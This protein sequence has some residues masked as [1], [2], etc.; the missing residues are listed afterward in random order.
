MRE[1]RHERE[2][3]AGAR[4][5]AL[6]TKQAP[7]RDWL[8]RSRTRIRGLEELKERWKRRRSQAALSDGDGKG[9]SEP[10]G[11]ARVARRVRTACSWGGK[12]TTS[13]RGTASN[14]F[15]RIEELR[16]GWGGCGRR[17]EACAAET[18]ILAR[19]RSW[20]RLHWITMAADNGRLAPRG[21]GLAGHGQFRMR[22]LWWGLRAPDINGMHDVRGYSCVI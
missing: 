7:A 17:G 5:A 10:S 4:H 2:R 15:L 6:D 3:G 13:G 11:E 12:V 22:F 9:A 21:A 1:R 14:P 19:W 8:V 18:P 16:G 20:E